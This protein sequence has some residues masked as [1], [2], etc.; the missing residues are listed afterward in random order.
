MVIAVN[1]PISLAGFAQRL[2]A[3]V[4]GRLGVDLGQPLRQQAEDDVLADGQRGISPSG[5]ARQAAASSGTG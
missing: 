4:A 2:Q 5:R 1:C 3:E